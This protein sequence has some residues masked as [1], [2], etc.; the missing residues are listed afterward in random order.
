MRP[1]I[2]YKRL[3]LLLLPVFLRKKLLAVWLLSMIAPVVFLYNLFVRYRDENSNALIKN[4]QVCYLRR[5]LNDAFPDAKGDIQIQGDNITGEW[6]YAWDKDLSATKY[7][8]IEN[9][10]F[11]D[12]NTTHQDIVGFIVVAPKAIYSMNN[13]TKIRSLLNAYKLIG[14]PYIIQ[15]K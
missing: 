6:E 3:I 4:G 13:D 14:K 12:E 2:E 7:L 11:W 8:L 15:Y 5:L 1:Q 10:L 9:T